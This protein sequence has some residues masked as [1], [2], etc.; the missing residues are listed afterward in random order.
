VVSGGFENFDVRISYGYEFPIACISYDLPDGASDPDAST[1]VMVV[2]EYLSAKLQDNEDIDFSYLGPSPFHANILV[3][4]VVGQDVC[5]T[6]KLTS[7]SLGY[8]HITV[9]IESVE[10]IDEIARFIGEYSNILECYYRIIRNRNRSHRI[11][12]RIVSRT[13]ELCDPIRLRWSWRRRELINEAFD[14]VLDHKMN[15]I[16]KADYVERRKRDGYID[17]TSPF[18]PYLERELSDFSI[19]PLDEVRDVLRMS[20]DRRQRVMAN[21]T[22]LVAGLIGGMVGSLL[23]FLLTKVATGH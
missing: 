12:E 15:D 10:P 7:N 23:T 17:E 3:M 16:D 11:G 5:V 4:Q 20:E 21:T 13:K 22:T 18:Y 8:D 19:I 6:C 9:R 2:R 14:A 1:S